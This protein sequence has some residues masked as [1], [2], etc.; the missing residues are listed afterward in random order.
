MPLDGTSETVGYFSTTNVTS[1]PNTYQCFGHTDWREDHWKCDECHQWFNNAYAH[2]HF[3]KPKLE[4]ELTPQQR[5]KLWLFEKRNEQVI[6]AWK[7][8]QYG[9]VKAQI[10]I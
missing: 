4:N 6:R 8:D 3:R 1:S 9:K 7:R 10:R 5:N 2:G